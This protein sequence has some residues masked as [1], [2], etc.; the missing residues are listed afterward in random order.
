VGGLGIK[1]CGSFEVAEVIVMDA[2]DERYPRKL[3]ACFRVAA[4]ALAAIVNVIF[5]LS[6]VCFL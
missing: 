1:G 3:T 5:V 2:V 4:V 6:N